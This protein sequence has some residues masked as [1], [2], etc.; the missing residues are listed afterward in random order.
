M[1]AFKVTHHCTAQ[2]HTRPVSTN[3][4]HIDVILLTS[5]VSQFDLL[6]VLSFVKIPPGEEA[7]CH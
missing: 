2:F 3:S 6:S 5:I 7:A 4:L 1:D